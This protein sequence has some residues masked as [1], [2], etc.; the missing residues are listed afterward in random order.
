MFTFIRKSALAACAII[1]LSAAPQAQA[2]TV[3]NVTGTDQLEPL[4]PNDTHGLG[5]VFELL[6]DL[7]N[8]SFG[9]RME[10]I[11]PCAG[12]IFLTRNN[13][14]TGISI[15]SLLQ[16]AEYFDDGSLTPFS[17]LDLMAGLYSFVV[18]GRE[19]F[20]GWYGANPATISTDGRAAYVGHG[21]IDGFDNGF[22]PESTWTSFASYT[23][24]LTIT[25][26]PVPS[27]VPLPASGLLLLAGLGAFAVR[28]KR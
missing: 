13:V 27:P 28:R 19:G 4:G 17:G 9:I 2:A 23:P 12:E 16:G 8:V 25:A 3:F 6:E 1:C 5:L 7:T 10:C 24:G 15:T 20:S 21:Q 11:G 14:L 18:V 26:D 22:P